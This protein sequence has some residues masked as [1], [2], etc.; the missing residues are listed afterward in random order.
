MD[1]FYLIGFV[2]LFVFYIWAVKASSDRE[3]NNELKNED[4]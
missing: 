2:G 1:V 4:E 3:Y